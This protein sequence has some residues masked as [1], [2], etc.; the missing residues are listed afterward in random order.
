MS[1]A[2]SCRLAVASGEVLE[3]TPECGLE[4]AELLKTEHRNVRR[5]GIN[6]AMP[7]RQAGVG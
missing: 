1:G 3:A 7:C 2:L 4:V 5:E 6:P